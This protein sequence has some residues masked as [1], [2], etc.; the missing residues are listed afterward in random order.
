MVSQFSPSRSNI[1]TTHCNSRNPPLGTQGTS[2]KTLICY[3]FMSRTNNQKKGGETGVNTI[4]A[5]TLKIMSYAL[6]GISFA[7]TWWLP[8]GL[9]LSFFTTGLLS[10]LQSRL[11]RWAPFRTFMN[12]TPIPDQP[13]PFSSPSSPTSPAATTSP[14]YQPPRTPSTTTT[15]SGGSNSDTKPTLLSNLTRPL[16]NSIQNI[17]ASARESINSAKQYS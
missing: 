13:D 3:P 8:A 12:M 15:T 1:P 7:F 10:F 2:S 16:K 9:Q 17:Q 5:G 14:S 6:P 11:F 4:S